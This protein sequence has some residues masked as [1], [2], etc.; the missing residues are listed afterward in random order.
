MTR[1]VLSETCI[2]THDMM[3]N[4]AAWTEYTE[5]RM[6]GRRLDH[7]KHEPRKNNPSDGVPVY[8]LWSKFGRYACFWHFE[9]GIGVVVGRVKS[10]GP[11]GRWRRFA[12]RSDVRSL[13]AAGVSLRSSTRALRSLQCSL[14]GRRTESGPSIERPISYLQYLDEASDARPCLDAGIGLGGQSG[15][16]R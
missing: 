7:A 8:L 10:D 13:E 14:C 5:P 16:W 12:T 1:S 4:G 15:D 11:D 6:F 9:Q 3:R 2:F